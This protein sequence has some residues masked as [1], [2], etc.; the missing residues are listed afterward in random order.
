MNGKPMAIDSSGFGPGWGGGLI[1]R[2]SGPTHS[3]PKSVI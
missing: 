3:G 1:L 2:K